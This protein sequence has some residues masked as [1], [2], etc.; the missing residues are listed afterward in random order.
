[1]IQE[2]KVTINLRTLTINWFYI[3]GSSLGFRSHPVHHQKYVKPT[4]SLQFWVWDIS[5]F[6]RNK[7]L[8]I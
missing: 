3:S 2:I 5:F 1:M 8:I 7:K 4:G 6:D